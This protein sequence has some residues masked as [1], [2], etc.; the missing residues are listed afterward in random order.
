MITNGTEFK[1]YK[2]ENVKKKLLDLDRK[3]LN[4]RFFGG[5]WISFEDIKKYKWV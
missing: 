1:C 4:K 5:N 3:L 2:C